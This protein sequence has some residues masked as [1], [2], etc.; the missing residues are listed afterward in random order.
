MTK[1]K[2][3]GWAHITRCALLLCPLI[4]SIG[5]VLWMGYKRHLAR[6]AVA[7]ESKYFA[8][9]YSLVS[10]NF[11]DP[12]SPENAIYHGAIPAMLR[13]LDPHSTFFDE[14]AF[15]RQNQAANGNYSGI[16]VELTYQNHQ[17][18]VVGCHSNSAAQRAGIHPGDLL[19]AVNGKAADALKASEVIGLLSGPEGTTTQ[20]SIVRDGRPLD[21][22]MKTEIMSRKSVADVAW[23]RPGIAYL[24]IVVFNEATPTELVANLKKCQ[25]EGMQGLI[26]DLRDNPGGLVRAAVGVADQFLRIGELILCQRGRAF[27]SMTY[28]AKHGNGGHE[29]PMVILVN[30]N[31]ASAAEALTGALQDHDR[32]WVLGDD[33][34][35]KGVVQTVNE[36]PEDTGLGLVKSRYY[37]PSGRLLQRKHYSAALGR[38]E[39]KAAPDMVAWITDSGRPVYA[40]AGVGPDEHY[41][42]QYDRFQSSLTSG[43][44]H[45][46]FTNQYLSRHPTK[47]DE[48][49]QPDDGMVGEFRDYVRQHQ[50]KF[51]KAEFARHDEWIR[52]RLRQAVLRT[53]FGLDETP[54]LLLATDAMVQRALDAMPKAQALLESAGRAPQNGHSAA[55]ARR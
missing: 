2:Q 55:V 27:P 24:A 5:S 29:Y 12:V 9:V 43:F 14:Q 28:V 42:P 44:A 52:Q 32:A 35:G 7:P 11:A 48:H 25:Q 31:T 38:Y 49:W 30:R 37:T 47:V 15:R 26:L 46:E 50:L 22:S 51:T 17:F 53:T 34:Y 6:V 33:T 10:A 16:G 13:A 18:I 41:A 8:R 39:R 20:L 3:R 36:L 21:F 19:A 23:I 1:L 40:S 4:L 54:R 45:L